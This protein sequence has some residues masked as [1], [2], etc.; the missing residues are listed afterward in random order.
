MPLVLPCFVSSQVGLGL[1]GAGTGGNRAMAG[2]AAPLGSLG[3]AARPR[4]RLPSGAPLFQ[5]GGHCAPRDGDC[6]A[7]GDKGQDKRQGSPRLIGRIGA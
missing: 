4:R 6:R 3:V 5:R 7:Y 1:V 2:A